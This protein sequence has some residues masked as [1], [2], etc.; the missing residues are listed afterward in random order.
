MGGTGTSLQPEARYAI[1]RS[2]AAAAGLAWGAVPEASAGRPAYPQAWAFV[3]AALPTMATV[4]DLREL[5]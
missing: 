2:A 1:A 4:E 3:P 5:T